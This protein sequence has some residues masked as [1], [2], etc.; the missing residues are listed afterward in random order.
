MIKLALV[1]KNIKHSMS[2][3]LYRRLLNGNVQYDLLDYKD[4]SEIPTAASLLKKYKGISITSP[5]KKH[6]LNEVTLSNDVS[7]LGAINCIGLKDDVLI[8]ENT[9]YQAIFKI[10][11]NWIEK[12]KLLSIIILGDGV[13]SNITKLVLDNFSAV[14]YIS[15]SRKTTESF[16][17]LNTPQLFL[18]AT[19]TTGQRIII[20]TCSREY[21]FKGVVDK[22]TIFWDFNY[23]FSPHLQYFANSTEQYVDGLSML[24]LQ[25]RYA[26][27]FWSIKASD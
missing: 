13:M 6:F 15:C 18:D 21:E 4:A 5:Y 26:L 17:R 23:C 14:K 8:G 3:E 16:T 11:S 20:N 27:S 24:E 2:P 25:A 10:V 7:S 1:G 22:D 9:D 12:Y 19:L